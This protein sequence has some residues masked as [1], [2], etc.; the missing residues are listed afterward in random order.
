MSSTEPRSAAPGP[1][2][3]FYG[4]PFAWLL[5]ALILLVVPLV[6]YMIEARMT[7]AQMH[8]AINA[9][10][11]GTSTV[12]LVA[13]YWAVRKRR[14]AFHKSCMVA[15]FVAS[16]VFL[17]SYLVRFAISG[18]HRYPGDGLDKV[19]YL[20]ILFSHMILAAVAVPLILR[21]LYLA[22]RDRLA[23]HARLARITWPIW[24]YVSVT[25]VIVYLMLYPLAGALYGS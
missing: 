1:R 23:D 3:P 20:V 11:N 2:R 9:L 5:F 13:G 4:K 7:W 22:W 14:L 21:S 18:T 24:M 19:V 6:G 15:A 17:A 16:S 10:L 8:P 12:F 25:G